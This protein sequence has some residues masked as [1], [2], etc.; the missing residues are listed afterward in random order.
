MTMTMTHC[1]WA[2]AERRADDRGNTVE[3]SDPGT[4]LIFL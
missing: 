1:K 2:K 4:D 3:G